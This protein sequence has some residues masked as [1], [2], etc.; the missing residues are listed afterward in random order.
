[1]SSATDLQLPPGVHSR[2]N[3]AA[4]L[5]LLLGLFSF[6]CFFFW[7]LG[8][9]GAILL[10]IAARGEIQRSEG[11]QHGKGVANTGIAFGVLHL[12]SLVIGSAVLFTIAASEKSAV[13]PFLPTAPPPGVV[14]SPAPSL[15]RVPPELPGA[16]TRETATRTLSLGEVTLVDPGTETPSLSVILD[17]ER[18]LSAEH[19]QRLVLF[20][21]GADCQPCNGVGV[22][23]RDARMQRA[24]RGVRLVRV[25]GREFAVELERNGIPTEVVPGFALIG[26]D[27]RTLDY[28]NGGEW[29]ADIPENIAPV[30][31]DF[32]AGRYLKRRNPW[33]PGG[34]QGETTL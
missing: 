15:S 3:A 14:V 1:V 33:K 30:L 34:A 21:V 17:R 11:Q 27:G 19:K 6:V 8:G 23:L 9:I 29:D 10:G 25:E 18:A 28:V 16:T 4:L 12:A 5:S 22:A 26:D 31:R 32:T 13:T 2:L 20:I 24:L 7:G